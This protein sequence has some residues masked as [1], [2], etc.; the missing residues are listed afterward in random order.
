MDLEETPS[1]F[2]FSFLRHGGLPYPKKIPL[3][4]IKNIDR[5]GKK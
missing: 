2:F 1:G 3:L 4:K 5:K